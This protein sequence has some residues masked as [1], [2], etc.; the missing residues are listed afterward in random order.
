MVKKLFVV[1][2]T[3]ALLAGVALAQDAKTVLQNATKAMGDVSRFSF[4][5]PGTCPRWAR[6]GIRPRRGRKP[7]SRAIP[8]PSTMARSPREELVR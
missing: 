3:P 5:A 6:L 8:R 7:L 1:L 4:P 2:P